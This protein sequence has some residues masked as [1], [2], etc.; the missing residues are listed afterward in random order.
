LCLLLDIIAALTKIMFALDPYADRIF[1]TSLCEI[2]F[3][4]FIPMFVTSTVLIAMFWHELATQASMHVTG[5]LTTLKIP[6]IFVILV[7]FILEVVS[8]SIRAEHSIK[9]DI[10]IL[11]NAIYYSVVIILMITYYCYVAWKVFQFLRGKDVLK[12]NDRILRDV[13]QLTPHSCTTR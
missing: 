12:K 10:V 7:L 13:R 6:A 1:P 9:A 3:T 2:F 4:A 5:G 8:A 11:V